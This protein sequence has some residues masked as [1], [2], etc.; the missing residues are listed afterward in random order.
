MLSSL[1]RLGG[2]E[3]EDFDEWLRKYNRYSD[4]MGYTE[5]EK[6]TYLPLY[7]VNR[8]EIFFYDLSSSDQSD[9]TVISDKFKTK[10]SRQAPYMLEQELYNR[11]QLPG[12]SVDSYAAA[13]QKLCS[14]L[15]MESKSR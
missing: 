5:A 12:E 4:I 3:N 11:S 14:K 1:S 6:A 15:K 13:I 7:L 8:A 2:A 10:F 9:F